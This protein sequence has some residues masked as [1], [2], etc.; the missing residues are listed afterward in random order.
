MTQK[1]A[2][3]T[4][5]ATSIAEEAI[6]SLVLILRQE[7]IKK[8]YTILKMISKFIVFSNKL[9]NIIDSKDLNTTYQYEIFSVLNIAEVKM[10]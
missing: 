2:N 5:F 6:F 1:I 8:M 7:Q 9:Q 10:V 3:T 4:I